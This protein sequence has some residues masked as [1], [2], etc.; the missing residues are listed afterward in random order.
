LEEPSQNPGGSFAARV[1]RGVVITTGGTGRRATLT[2]E[3]TGLN[4]TGTSGKDKEAGSGGEK[5]RGG[6]GGEEKGGENRGTGKTILAVELM[7]DSREA[8]SER[9]GLGN[10]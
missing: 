1:N 10:D 5:E 7:R 9:T 4:T 3:A 6:E 2:G 8:T